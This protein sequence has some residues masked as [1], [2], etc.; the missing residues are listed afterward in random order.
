[1]CIFCNSCRND[2]LNLRL[3]HDIEKLNKLVTRAGGA[4]LA[5]GTEGDSQEVHDLKVLTEFFSI[6]VPVGHPNIRLLLQNI[7]YQWLPGLSF[8]FVFL[9]C[10]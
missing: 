1:M 8:T 2:E 10:L 3:R 5:V 4:S 9:F 7:S 6:H